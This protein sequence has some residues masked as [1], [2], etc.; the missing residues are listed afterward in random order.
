MGGSIGWGE[1]WVGRGVDLILVWLFVYLFCSLF[2]A[3]TT[4]TTTV[5][6]HG[7]TSTKTT[8]NNSHGTESA[9]RGVNGTLIATAD[10]FGMVKLMRYPCV[11]NSQLSKSYRGHR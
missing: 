3:V 4:V 10:D 8:T 1:H 11:S 9:T 7:T 2:L 6:I 5:A